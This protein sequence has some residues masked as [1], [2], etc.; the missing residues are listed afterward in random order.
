M[1]ALIDL[2]TQLAPSRWDIYL[3]VPAWTSYS[4]TAIT[5]WTSVQLKD[6]SRASVPTGSGIYVLVLKPAISAKDASYLMYIGQASNLRQ[7]FSQYLTT[8]RRGRRAKIVR[9][10][11]MYPDHLWFHHTPVAAVDLDSVEDTLIGAFL[12]PCNSEIEGQFGPARRAF[13]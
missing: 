3:H 1:A 9:L 7:R 6:L 10:L 8:E 2:I 11:N 12:P 13:G 5:N 4:G